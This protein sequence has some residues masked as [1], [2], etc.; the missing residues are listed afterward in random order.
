MW[1]IM[2]QKHANCLSFWMKYFTANGHDG[3]DQKRVDS[4]LTQGKISPIK[5]DLFIW[6]YFFQRLKTTEMIANKSELEKK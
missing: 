1:K 4:D 2:Q 5:S 6:I 3:E